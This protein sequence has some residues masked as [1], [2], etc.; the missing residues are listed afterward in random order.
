MKIIKTADIH[1]YFPVLGFDMKNLEGAPAGKYYLNGNSY[2][3]I[4]LYST[5]DR[6]N[7]KYESHK[8]YIDIQLMIEGKEIIS[9]SP[10]NELNLCTSYDV[11]KDVALYRGDK[12]GTDILLSP[13]EALILF[14]QDGHMP[15]ISSCLGRSENVIKA[16]IKTPFDESVLPE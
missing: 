10:V 3:N 7:K 6:G 12:N 4:A 16:V 8:K 1:R 5:S 13:G 11:E 15:G 14:P 2:Y 9:V